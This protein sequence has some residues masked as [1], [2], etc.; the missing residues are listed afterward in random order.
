MA[1]MAVLAARARRIGSAEQTIR[2]S[3]QDNLF[4]DV[5]HGDL[6]AIARTVVSLDAGEASAV[7]A[8]LSED[9]LGVWIRELDGWQGGF[10][11]FEQARLFEVLAD[12]LN[13]Q[14]LRRLI[15][16]GKAAELIAAVSSSAPPTVAVPLA[17]MLWGDR[18][19]TDDGWEQIIGLL[20]AAPPDVVEATVARTSARSLASDLLGRHQARSDGPV[21][22]QL[23]AMASFLN[24][25]GGFEDAQLKAE[26]FLV[27]G[28]QLRFHG[29]EHVVG[30]VSSGDVLGRLGSL[31]RSDTAAV[32]TRL[33]HAADPHGNL[34][35][36][37]IQDMIEADRVDELDVLLTD[38]LGGPNRV[39]FFSDPGVDP[40][41]PY[42][43]AA[44]LGYYVGAYS[45]AIDNI[46]E[47]AFDQ[48][49]LVTN[50]FTLVTGV[51]P[52]PDGSKIRLPFSPLVD[53]HADAVID[54]LRDQSATLKQTLWGL[55]KPRT[56]DGAAWNGAGTTQFQ[57]A[58]EEVVI[59][60]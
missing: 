55:A 45:L 17:L 41:R 39:A 59:V 30:D 42:P 36:A 47:D 18:S 32:M 44:N 20:A 13:A 43:N 5:G 6:S 10:N 21:K 11:R 12:R 23:D 14:Q 60:R 53:V 24:L 9:E 19:P 35:S 25:A 38:L 28:E 33:N 48:I 29:R 50:L 57:D 37:W 1:G 34:T 51:V 56:P 52:G 4:S 40:A 58:W 54:D 2:V 49:H 8:A 31:I 16:H 15:A 22:L 7:V 27:A 46:A 3:L 26:L